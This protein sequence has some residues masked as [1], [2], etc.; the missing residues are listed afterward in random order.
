MTE[1]KQT[2]PILDW[3]R[4]NIRN[5]DSG[6]A[7]ALAARLRRAG[8]IDA[9]AEPEVHQLARRL[10]RGIGGAHQ[11]VRLVQVLAEIREDDPQ[12]LARRF[13]GDPATLSPLR[14]QR[15]LRA[16]DDEFVSAVRRAMPVVDRRCNVRALGQDLL[17]WDAPQVG[18]RIRTHW[19]F[20]YFGT[21]APTGTAAPNTTSKLE[22]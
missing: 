1:A 20:D 10:G 3:W 19:C 18:D 4:V 9:L 2:D 17:G 7:R 13:G 12:R 8:P 22:V 14:F 16:R 15:L 5:R 21:E 6:R 11:L